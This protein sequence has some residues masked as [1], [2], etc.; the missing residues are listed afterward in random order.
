MRDLLLFDLERA[1]VRVFSLSPRAWVAL[2]P[3]PLPRLPPLASLPPLGAILTE[4]ILF[5]F[6]S[7]TY[8]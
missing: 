2:A 7:K 6:I 4:F 1:G 8:N 3:L 5:E